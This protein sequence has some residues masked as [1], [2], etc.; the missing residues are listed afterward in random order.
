MK[1][2]T[3]AAIS[4][5]FTQH[6]LWISSKCI[7]MSLSAGLGGASCFDIHIESL[8]F[9]SAD[10]V[11]PLSNLFIKGDGQAVFEQEVFI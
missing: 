2:L 3:L 1:S 6:G 11:S 4:Q 5:D 9:E 7:I 10:T 8:H